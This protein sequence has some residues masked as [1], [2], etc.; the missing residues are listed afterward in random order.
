MNATLRLFL[1]GLA[2]AG[3]IAAVSAPAHAVLQ[4]AADVSGTP[5]FCA[6][7]SPT[8]CDKNPAV[9]VIQLAD[10][11]LNGVAVNGSIQLSTG[12]PANPGLDLL[13]TSSLSVINGSGA[14]RVVTVAVSDT[15]F[16]APVKSFHLTGSGTWVNAA[17]SS[18]LLKWFDDPANTQ[19]ADTAFDAPG[20]LLGTFMSAGSNPLLSFSTDQKGAVSDTGPF[21]MTLWAQATL[22]PGGVLLDRGQGEVKTPIP[23]LSTWAMIGLGFAALGFAG[24]RRKRK[25]RIS[26][27]A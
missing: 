15:S 11:T 2:V 4:I 19:G 16:S 25:D 24:Y 8:G 12:T 23:E 1:S 14:T 3:L 9:G 18:L 17:G 7:N 27:F 26:A 10:D 21:S 6:D 5:F 20:D 13:D 22:N